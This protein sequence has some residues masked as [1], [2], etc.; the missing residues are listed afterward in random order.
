MK[1]KVVIGL[2]GGVDSAVSA[3]LLKQ[4]GYDVHALFMINW[5]NSSVTLSGDCTWEELQT[6]HDKMETELGKEGAFVDA[7]YICPHHPDK[8][9]KG[10]H[11][12]YKMLCDCR[13]PKP[14]L[15]IQAA[16]DNNIDL[17]ESFMIGDS[18][19][20]LKTSVN[21]G[22]K[23]SCKVDSNVNTLFSILNNLI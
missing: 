1:K 13:K 23:L 15:L 22:C 21:A 6:I 12:E 2:S 8:G 19:V 7:I 20:D 3:L 18:E 9:F 17:S 11:P 14:G 5:K 16:K 4:Q 10:E